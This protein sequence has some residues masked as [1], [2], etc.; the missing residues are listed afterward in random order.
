MRRVNIEATFTHQN[1]H[2]FINEAAKYKPLKPE[3]EATATPDQLVKHN[4]LFVVSVA[5]QY[6]KNPTELKDLI[7][8]GLI[9]LIKAA[10]RYDSTKGFKFISYAVW[11][12]QQQI[13]SY[14]RDY[15]PLVKVTNSQHI[16]NQRISN[17][18]DMHTEEEIK[19][20]L[21]ITDKIFDNYIHKPTFE[22]MDELLGDDG[23]E[24]RQYTD[25]HD[26]TL[27]IENE[28]MRE[29]LLGIMSCLE[30]KEQFIIHELYLKPFPSD[31][32]SIANTMHIAYET[33]RYFHKRALHKLRHKISVLDQ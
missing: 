6:T 21:N 7:S 1:I 11:W 26:F 30:Y 15:K 24:Q 28:E 10:Q 9:G 13:M 16:Y 27:N 17:L 29:R 32:Q 23:D 19:T 20:K 14:L 2:S 22:Y 33:V 4:M 18:I 5:K 31:V 25:G 3:E 12:I 8:E